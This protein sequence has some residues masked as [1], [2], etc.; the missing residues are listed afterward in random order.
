M[1]DRPNIALILSGRHRGDATGCAS[2]PA[3]RTP[4]L[5][6]VAAE[7]VAGGTCRSRGSGLA[8]YNW[9]A[10]IQSQGLRTRTKG[11]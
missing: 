9:L 5:D 10:D 4:N 11:E 3:A 6:R 2:N 7:G 8:V 1:V